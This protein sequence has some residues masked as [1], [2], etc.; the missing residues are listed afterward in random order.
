MAIILALPPPVKFC[1][2]SYKKVKIPVDKQ[3]IM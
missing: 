1:K 3:K 2:N